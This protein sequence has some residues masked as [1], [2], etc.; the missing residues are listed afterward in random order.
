MRFHFHRQ[1]LH[2]LAAT[3][4]IPLRAEQRFIAFGERVENSVCFRYGESGQIEPAKKI[5]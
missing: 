2:G 4:G 3:A 5:R 1:F